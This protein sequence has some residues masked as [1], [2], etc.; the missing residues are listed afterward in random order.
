MNSK[1]N[2]N[3]TNIQMSFKGI[4]LQYLVFTPKDAW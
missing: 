1:V 2:F 4:Q 3:M